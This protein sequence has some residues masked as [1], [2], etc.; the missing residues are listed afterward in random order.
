MDELLGFVQEHGSGAGA[1]LIV[2]LFYLER[3]RRDLRHIGRRLKL[4]ETKLGIDDDST[5]PGAS[6]AIA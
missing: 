4:V 1:L 3:I 2:T 6:P 5:P